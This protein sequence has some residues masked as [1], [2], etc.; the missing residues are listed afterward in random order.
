VQNLSQSKV[1]LW[2]TQNAS[3]SSDWNCGSWRARQRRL[4]HIQQSKCFLR[5]TDEF[6]INDYNLNY[7]QNST[8]K[9]REH[10]GRGEASRRTNDNKATYL[11]CNNTR[12]PCK[13]FWRLGYLQQVSADQLFISTLVYFIALVWL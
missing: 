6:Y 8:I 5:W 10:F 12:Q 4:E 11:C 1:F 9:F 2:N 7:F 3:W 13:C